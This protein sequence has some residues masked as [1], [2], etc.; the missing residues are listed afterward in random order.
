MLQTGTKHWRQIYCACS[1]DTVWSVK[2]D[3]CI[4]HSILKQIKWSLKIECSRHWYQLKTSTKDICSNIIKSSNTYVFLWVVSRAI[5]CVER[6]DSWCHHKLCINR[7]SLVSLQLIIQT[8]CWK[9]VM[10]ITPTTLYVYVHLPNFAKASKGYLMNKHAK[11]IGYNIAHQ[12]HIL[13]QHIHNCRNTYWESK[14]DDLEN[15]FIFT[16]HYDRVS[17]T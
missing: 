8:G 2:V 15:Y 6:L 1:T 5:G 10:L 16:D 11:Y 12:L 13:E 14:G 7:P 17:A 9:R 4:L 3:I